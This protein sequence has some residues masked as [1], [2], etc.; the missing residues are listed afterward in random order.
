MSHDERP[1]AQIALQYLLT[2][3]FTHPKTRELL[4]DSASNDPDEQLREWAQQQL[5]KIEK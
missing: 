4:R 3:Y 1:P 5:E 2:N